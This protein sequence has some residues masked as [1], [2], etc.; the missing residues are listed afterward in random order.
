MIKLVRINVIAARVKYSKRILINGPSHKQAY[1][2]FRYTEA[3]PL[4]FVN[5]ESPYR[6]HLHTSTRLINGDIVLV[7][8]RRPLC[9][10]E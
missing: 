8:I 9:S 7:Q 4:M 2:S 3:S 10:E 6:F 5:Q 1:R